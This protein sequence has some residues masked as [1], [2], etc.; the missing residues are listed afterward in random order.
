[1]AAVGG[2]CFAP[3]AHAATLEFC[4]SAGERPCATLTVP[5]DRSG[6]VPGTI[7]LRIERQRA[8]QPARPPL[9]LIAG[10]PG[11]SAI[12]SF[13]SDTVQRL[14]GTEA[15]A[16]D[17][18]VVDLR[19]TG[20]SGLLR[21]PSLERSEGDAAA[22][23]A[24][25][26][27]RLGPARAFY[28]AADAADDLDA[29]RRALGAPRIALFGVSYGTF[30]A[31]TYAR[32]YPMTVERM[33]LDSV[34]GPTGID[35]LDRP[36]LQ[37]A[38]RVLRVF[39]GRRC[40]WTRDIGSDL[41]RLVRRLEKTPMRGLRTDRRGRRLPA[42]VGAV[43]LLSV[44]VS[45]DVDPFVRAKTPGAIRN[46]L[47][48]DAAPLLRIARQVTAEDVLFESPRAL[49][50]AAYA[51][52]I[53]AD[54][55]FPWDPM[56][57]PDARRQQAS[58][59]VHGLPAGTFGPFG[60]N[61]ALASGTLAL[62]S[63]WPA[64]GRPAPAQAQLPAVPTLLLSGR[65]DLRTP[66]ENARAVAA[67]LPGAEL[68]DVVALGHGVLGSTISRCAGAAFTR[69]LAGGRAGRCPAGLRP[70]PAFAPPPLGLGEVAPVGGRRDRPGRI[71]GA[72]SL[73]VLVGFSDALTD[74]SNLVGIGSAETAA[75]RS[76]TTAALR[77]GRFSF[78]TRSNGFKVRHASYVP[79]VRVHGQLRLSRFAFGAAADDESTRIFDSGRLVVSGGAAHGK[80]TV[81]RG[82]A[83]GVLG[84]RRVRF[85]I[86][87]GKGFVSPRA[88]SRL[89][90]LSRQTTRFR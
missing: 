39:C 56:A 83:R 79:G 27:A 32:R 24:A 16:R 23:G 47:R 31:Q 48:G 37:A 59:L 72:T 78:D 55:A 8:S 41:T 33:V 1:M 67:E 85:P 70:F 40:G 26:A 89:A 10:G 35:P 18:V 4:G 57:S 54:S 36:S 75:P 29:V 19:G 80:L 51:A 45:G 74:M 65:T 82:I 86:V 46:A 20:R 88:S 15:R 5:L 11:Q 49:S 13:D 52:A 66:L 62:C 22:A 84:G 81:R 21:C 69:F 44:L 12:E 77:G 76:L 28:T 43:G 17:V 73:T 6:T 3:A 68:I 90:R 42:R 60:A 64:S 25:C 9:F 53:C 87:S 61:T 71:A 50:P 38:P 14:L 63:A 30:V 58:T 34:V 7:R 2:A